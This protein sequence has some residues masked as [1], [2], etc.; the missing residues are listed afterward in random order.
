MTPCL[1][2]INM[3][4]VTRLTA[5]CTKL[6]TP[7][8]TQLGV[9]RLVWATKSAHH[10]HLIGRSTFV[11]SSFP[12]RPSLGRGGV[13]SSRP[14]TTPAGGAS[15]LPWRS[16]HPSTK[17]HLV[18][19]SIYRVRLPHFELSTITLSVIVLNYQLHGWPNVPF[20]L[21][22]IACVS[23]FVLCGHRGD[24]ALRWSVVHSFVPEAAIWRKLSHCYE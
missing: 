1:P 18:Y 15:G 5:A 7:T 20:A 16:L 13:N 22:N 2:K 12:C 21:Y 6:H 10:W 9:L 23:S 24:A 17:L 14:R 3:S 19:L 11:S 8:I 4:P